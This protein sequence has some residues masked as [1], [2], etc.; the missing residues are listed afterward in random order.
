MITFKE[1][2]K[3]HEIKYFACLLAGATVGVVFY[4]T[5]TIEERL[6]KKYEQEIKTVKEAHLKE[7][8]RLNE[9]LTK[10]SS[11]F[12]SYKS[13]TEMKLSKSS[14]EIKNLKKKQKTSYFK[15]IKPD[16][17]IEIKKFSESDV[18]ESTKVVEQIQQEF[19]SKI[20]SIEKKW[21]NVHEQRVKDIVRDFSEKESSYLRTIAELQRS[22]VTKINQKVFSVDGG[23]LST[24]DYYGHATMDLWG[25][26]VIGVHGQFGT[27]N[28]V[29]AG[30]GLRF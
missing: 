14:E 29:G 20:D 3:R 18:E 2:M 1:L 19:K 27:I 12:S 13:E 6:N 11:E 21:E 10:T 15:L 28:A 25:P 7:K 8:V 26:I 4:P 23:L 16:G 17:T 22:K 24:S 30:L 5:K 9:Q